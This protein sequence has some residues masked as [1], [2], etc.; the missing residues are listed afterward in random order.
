MFTWKI[1]TGDDA[2][3]DSNEEDNLDDNKESKDKSLVG[4]QWQKKYMSDINVESSAMHLPVSNKSPAKARNWE[5]Y[6]QQPAELHK[7]KKADEKMEM[8][9][10]DDG[11]NSPD[12][13]PQKERLSQEPTQKPNKKKKADKKEKTKSKSNEELTSKKHACDKKIEKAKEKEVL[14][15]KT[16]DKVV[17]KRKS[18][19]D[20]VDKS[21]SKKA[22]REKLP[23][24]SRKGDELAWKGAAKG[25]ENKK[26]YE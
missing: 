8:E 7:Q 9:N 18:S 1:K 14:P 13:L 3:Y 15:N 2:P 10:K 5:S 16:M 11:D 21:L 22:K 25:E 23:Q 12:K 24:E 19:K 26:S 4:E 20:H 17:E 6:E